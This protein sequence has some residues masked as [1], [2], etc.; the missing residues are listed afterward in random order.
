M[1]YSQKNPLKDIQ[2]QLAEYMDSLIADLYIQKEISISYASRRKKQSL[3]TSNLP[4]TVITRSKHQT[5]NRT[6]HVLFVRL[7]IGI[8]NDILL[9]TVGSSR[10]STKFEL[11]KLCKLMLMRIL[12]MLMYI[13]LWS[14][15]LNPPP[16]MSKRSNVMF[17]HTS[18]HFMVIVQPTLFLTLM[19]LHH[20]Y[21]SQLPKLLIYQLPQLTILQEQQINR[22]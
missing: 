9:K 4:Q 8:T 10:S 6:I 22:P 1:T 14:S 17:L 21:P 13:H 16:V 7:K 12:L 19:P 15:M 20:L 5:E 11:Q 3:P 2:P 18:M